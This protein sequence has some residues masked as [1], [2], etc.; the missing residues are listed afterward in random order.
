VIVRAAVLT[1]Q[2]IDTGRVDLLRQAV[3][4]LAEADSV[5][6]VDNGSRDGTADLVAGWGGYVSCSGLTTSGHGTNLCA[7]V[8]AATDAEICVLSDDDMA[9]RP[10]W[11][12][13]LETWW[14]DAP[15]D[16]W[17]TGC[18][19]EPDYPWN[20][21]MGT[22]TVGGIVGVLRASTGAASWS[23]RRSRHAE[24]FPIPQQVQGWGDVP[25][26]DAIHE[27]GGRIA[28]LELADHAGHGRSTWGNQT[29]AKYGHDVEAVR[30]RLVA[31]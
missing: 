14:S 30:R 3:T 17:L 29:A 23:Y 7:R 9:W 24:I 18:H 8:L 16:V 28:Q 13:R 22:L 15:D 25:A 27:R 4:S 6:V 19:L 10:G 11:R 5:H 2:A 31:S 21:S 20:E 1:Y 12:D 26:C